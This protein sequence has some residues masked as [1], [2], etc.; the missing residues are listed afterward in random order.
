MDA[1]HQLVLLLLVM[2]LVHL[3]DGCYAASRVLT[4]NNLCSDSADHCHAVAAM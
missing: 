1:L 2:L 3:V 4:L